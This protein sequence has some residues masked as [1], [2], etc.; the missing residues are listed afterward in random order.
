MAATASSGPPRADGEAV[1]NSIKPRISGKRDSESDRFASKVV[2]AAANGHL[3]QRHQRNVD[4]RQFE[5][6]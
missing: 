4:T 5:K 2:K 1:M 6:A 3:Q